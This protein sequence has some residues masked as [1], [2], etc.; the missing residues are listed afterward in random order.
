[1][2]PLERLLNLVILLLETSR[3]LSFEQIRERL[4]A[5]DQEGDEAA[6]RMF[7]R[8]KDLLRDL[9]VP[10]EVASTDA[11]EVE[12]GYRIPKDQYYLPE[13]E[14]D[15]EEISALFVAAQSPSESGEAGEAEQAVRKLQAGVDPSALARL[16]PRPLAAG[17]DVAAGR[18]VAVTEAIERRSSV[19][20]EYRVA[21]GEAGERHVDPYSLVWRAG[22]W[23]LVGLDRDRGEVRSFRLSRFR[24]DP[25][26]AG[27]GSAPPE[28]FNAREHVTP[29]RRGTSD[30]PVEARVAFSPDVAWW[31]APPEA[32]HVRTLDDGWVEMALPADRGEWFL[33]WVL[34]FGP[35]AVLLAPRE[36]RDEAVRRLEALR[37][38]G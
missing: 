20:F 27:P 11:W 19:R 21:A 13:M 6:K 26:E 29:G 32:R 24:S 30:E 31:A 37:E 12:Q 7:E 17:A 22:H 4:P 28:R 36:L 23:Y 2:H 8:D 16:S 18:L 10:V 15:E 33:S 1:M 25:K 38:A 35:D 9:G 34:S 14:F 5:Y 3:P